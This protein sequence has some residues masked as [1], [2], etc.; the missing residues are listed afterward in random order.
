MKNSSTSAKGKSGEQHLPVERDIPREV[1]PP[2]QIHDGP[3]ER[4]VQGD[5]GMAE[6]R[7]P[8]FIPERLFERLAERQ[9]DVLDGVVEINVDVSPRLDA[10][11]ETRVARERIEHVV[12]E[13]DRRPDV[14]RDLSP[15]RE[16][17]PDRS[18][19]RLAFDESAVHDV[20]SF[21]A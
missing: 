12:E 3:G 13:P 16:L 14:R 4:L 21:Q 20:T 15:G 19:L 9:A 18:L 5:V 1:R 7:Y 2:G 10:Q 11:A 6:A 8:L 17:Q